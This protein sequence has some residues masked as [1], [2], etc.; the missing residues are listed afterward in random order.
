MCL[1]FVSEMGFF[2]SICCYYILKPYQMREF[3]GNI[4]QLPGAWSAF[5]KS[6]SVSQLVAVPLKSSGSRTFLCSRLPAA[7]SWKMELS[8]LEEYMNRDSLTQ[9]FV[10]LRWTQLDSN[11]VP[12]LQQGLH[13]GQILLDTHSSK[14][15]R[16]SA[17]MHCHCSAC[18][19][20]HTVKVIKINFSNSSNPGDE[21]NILGPCCT[22]TI[23]LNIKY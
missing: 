16:S 14:M 11:T 8:G 20:L 21:H 4:S 23:F 17:K 9:P 6:I 1:Y 2:Y 22:M 18:K 13:Y 7:S 12:A 15:L 19:R 10:W 3:M 5:S